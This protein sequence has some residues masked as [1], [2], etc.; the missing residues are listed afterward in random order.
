MHECPEVYIPCEHCQAPLEMHDYFDH[1]CLGRIEEKLDAQQI[2]MN[3]LREELERKTNMIE[4][5][6]ENEITNNNK[7]NHLN[8]RN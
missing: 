1:K 4:E 2:E 8:Q 7:I 3:D 6:K 5:L